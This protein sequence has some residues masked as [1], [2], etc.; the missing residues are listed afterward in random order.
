MY[1]GLSSGAIAAYPIYVASGTVMS[2]VVG[3]SFTSSSWKAKAPYYV[4]PERLYQMEAQHSTLEVQMI[5]D[6]AQTD[7]PDTR[8]EYLDWLLD[9]G[10]VH[11]ADLVK[12]GWVPYA[13]VYGTPLE[14]P[15]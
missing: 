6:L 1:P 10:R 11:S 4:P 3:P 9:H 12:R 13:D 14:E 15:Q 2:G 7:D 5:L 8:R